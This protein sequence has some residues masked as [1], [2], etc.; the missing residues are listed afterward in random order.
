MRESGRR[1]RSPSGLSEWAALAGI[2]AALAAALSAVAPG[3]GWLWD[4]TG[5]GTDTPAESATAFATRGTHYF[6]SDPG[7]YYDI[8][9]PAEK[10]LVSRSAWLKC[11]GGEGATASLVRLTPTGQASEPI[12]RAGVD[13]KF[14]TVIRFSLLVDTP[15]GRKSVRSAMPI[16]RNDGHWTRLF[17][18]P[19]YPSEGTKGC[20]E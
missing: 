12:D 2:A 20:G 1:L 8:L 18:N 16:V 5:G 11:F 6:F 10:R 13:E 3:V 14:A 9:H 15:D 17:L 7:G 4:V 19:G